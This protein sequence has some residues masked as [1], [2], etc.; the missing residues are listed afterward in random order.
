MQ[1]YFVTFFQ[2]YPL[3]TFFP[4]F[5]SNIDIFQSIFP[6]ETKFFSFVK[7]YFLDHSKSLYIHNA[8]RKHL[9]FSDG[10]SEH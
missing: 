10:G 1:K 7:I 3:K 6:L 4:L 9:I 8:Y 5:S 2:G